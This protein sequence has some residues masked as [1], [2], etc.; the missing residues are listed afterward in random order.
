MRMDGYIIRK[1]EPV[2]WF[3]YDDGKT[4]E[5]EAGVDLW[6]TIDEAGNWNLQPLSPMPARSS[7]LVVRDRGK[8][9]NAWGPCARVN[10][11]G[12]PVLDFDPFAYAFGR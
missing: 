8:S 6:A 7:A 2:N 12:K 3:K 9:E 4:V 11:N 1:G 10:L 5:C